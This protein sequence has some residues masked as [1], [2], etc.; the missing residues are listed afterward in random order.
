MLIPVTY[1]WLSYI[2]TL[3][4]LN[5]HDHLTCSFSD[6][7]KCWPPRLLGFQARPVGGTGWSIEGFRRPNNAWLLMMLMTFN[8]LMRLDANL[9][10]Y[11]YGF[12]MFL[13]RETGT[14]SMDI[15]DT[16]RYSIWGQVQTANLGP[17]KMERGRLHCIL[18]VF[19]FVAR[20]VCTL[21]DWVRLRLA[22]AFLDHDFR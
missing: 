7:F 21:R 18:C 19:F 4:Y 17:L 1:C 10:Q 6:F 2:Y 20:K 3:N 11:E 15:L 8:D 9:M 22:C 13:D 12:L 14:E 16:C 5:L